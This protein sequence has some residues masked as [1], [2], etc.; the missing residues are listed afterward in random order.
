MKRTRF[1][2]LCLN[3]SFMSFIQDALRHI[4]TE[5][6]QEVEKSQV[7]SRL[8]FVSCSNN[9]M[10]LMD[11]SLQLLPAVQSLD[12]SRNR[13][14]KAANL[15]CCSKLTYLDLGFNQ[16]RNISSLKQVQTSI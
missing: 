12:L 14:V 6:I 2:F 8:A 1:L 13:F 11:D 9:D 3:L 5:R 7:W 10:V 4:F 15:H 16:L